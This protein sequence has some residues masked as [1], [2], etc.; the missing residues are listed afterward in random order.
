M[1]RT[2]SRV[3]SRGITYAEKIG[4]AL[5]DRGYLEPNDLEGVILQ[6]ENFEGLVRNLVRSF[7]HV[8]HVPK[9]QN[10]SRDRKKERA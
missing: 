1:I 3:G 10:A 6:E 5:V 4:T 8:V 9:R 2:D 7:V